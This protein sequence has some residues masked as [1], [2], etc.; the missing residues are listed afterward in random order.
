MLCINDCP[1]DSRAGMSSCV[2]NLMCCLLDLLRLYHFSS[3]M[4]REQAKPKVKHPTNLRCVWK[5]L[6]IGSK[7]SNHAV[8]RR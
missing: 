3:P 1:R 6:Q 5:V 2:H 7:L 4:S 8:L